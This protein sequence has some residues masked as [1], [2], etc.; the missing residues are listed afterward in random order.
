MNKLSRDVHQTIVHTMTKASERSA[1]PFSYGTSWPE[2]STT[3]SEI[4]KL[5][6]KWIGALVERL[7]KQEKEIA[8]L[9]SAVDELRK[10]N[11]LMATSAAEKKSWSESLFASNKPSKTETKLLA[12]VA[13]ENREISKRECNIVISGLP[14]ADDDEAEK[15]Q[16]ETL[17]TALNLDMENVKASRRLTPARKAPTASAAATTTTV[18]AAS[19]SASTSSATT[20]LNKSPAL[21][22]E[23]RDKHHV[24]RAL[25]MARELKN[26]NDF[27]RV[28]VSID[29]T[30]AE[31]K[32][33][34]EQRRIRD[35][36]NKKLPHV[37]DGPR[38]RQR[39]GTDDNGKK[40]FWAI[41]SGVA[42]KIT[43]QSA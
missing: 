7:V 33:E 34:Y 19:S 1:D 32:E 20:A 40:F 22:V 43:I 37:E 35:E 42:A 29:K 16:L 5:Q 21:L 23:L 39:Y 31:R 2:A 18:T 25:Q 12:R 41:R 15:E 28:Y 30:A 13:R 6:H 9:K 26:T 27:K 24:D 14:V 10:S 4:N 3:S 8:E 38:G 11:E 36:N 17:L